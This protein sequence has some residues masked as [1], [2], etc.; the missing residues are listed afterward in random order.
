[1]RDVFHDPFHAMSSGRERMW[2]PCFDVRET[3]EAFLFKADLPGV[4]EDDVEIEIHGKRL[5]ITGK[6]ED[7]HEEKDGETVYA[8]ERSFGSFYRAFTLPENADIEQVTCELHDG[9][10]TVIVPKKA[11]PQPRKIRVGKSKRG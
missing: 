1:M 5:A 11:G 10:L 9:V 8:F 7:E 3:T 6:R 4:R 2:N